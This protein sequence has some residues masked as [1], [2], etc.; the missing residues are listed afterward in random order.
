MVT[1]SDAYYTHKQMALSDDDVH[2]VL[3]LAYGQ[4]DLH[5]TRQGAALCIYELEHR[6]AID[7]QKQKWRTHGFFHVDP[8]M[9]RYL[10]VAKH[11]KSVPCL[12]LNHVEGHGCKFTR[13]DCTNKHVCILCGEDGHGAFQMNK[14]KT[15]QP[16][17]GFF[18]SFWMAYKSAQSYFGGPSEMYRILEGALKNGLVIAEIKV[19]ADGPHV[20]WPKLLVHE[21]KARVIAWIKIQNAI[22][23]AKRDAAVS[24]N[25]EGGKSEFSSEGRSAGAEAGYV[26]IP[27]TPAYLPSITET[28][29]V[30]DD[31]VPDFDR[32]PE[33]TSQVVEIKRKEYVARPP[34]SLLRPLVSQ[35]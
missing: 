9:A 21:K 28:D 2:L 33:D 17:C 13:A 8:M 35:L 5:C 23:T 24:G 20:P 11:S 26:T 25:G 1:T 29:A 4:E 19:A 6:P 30:T 7:T 27:N 12:R 14:F 15:N 16:L 32:A 18:S 31:A 22:L 34:C 10:A 3:Q